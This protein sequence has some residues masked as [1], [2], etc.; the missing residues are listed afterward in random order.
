MRDPMHHYP[1]STWLKLIRHRPHPS[2]IN[3]SIPSN[4]NSWRIKLSSLSIYI[5]IGNNI[6]T[7]MGP[8]SWNTNLGYYLA[9]NGKKPHSSNNTI[10][11]SSIKI[12][13]MIRIT[14]NQK[15]Y[16][17]KYNPKMTKIKIKNLYLELL[18]VPKLRTKQQENKRMAK[19]V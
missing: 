13:Q 9:I 19:R 18:L 17:I 6:D 3:T 4:Y 5:P 11:S 7:C 14:K 2:L 12:K 10:V 1:I 16:K 8:N 15:I